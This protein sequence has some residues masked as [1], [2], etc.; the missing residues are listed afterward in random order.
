MTLTG[1]V[2]GLL[3]IA[4]VVAIMMLVGAVIVWGLSLMAM[5]V[6]ATVQKGY[7]VVVGLVAL[8]M[9]AALLFGIPTIHVITSGI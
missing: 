4:L 8:Y 7:M 1:L 5:P 3:N 9:V 2:L 6:P